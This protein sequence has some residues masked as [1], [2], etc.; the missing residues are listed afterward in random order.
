MK[1]L[2]DIADGENGCFSDADIV[3]CGIFSQ[4][5]HQI[6]PLVPGDLNHCDVGDDVGP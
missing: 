2:T 3:I 4:D 5:V 6:E 1:L